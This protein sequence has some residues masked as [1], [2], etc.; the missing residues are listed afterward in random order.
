MIDE[1]YIE[2]MNG[3]IDGMNSPEESRELEEYLKTHPEAQSHFDQLHALGNIFEEAKR[4]TPPREMRENV[5]SL[6]FDEKQRE[7]SKRMASIVR[8]FFIEQPKRRLLYVFGTG[9]VVGLLLFSLIVL[10]VP[11]GDE[12]DFRKLYGTL[13]LIKDEKMLFISEPISFNVSGVSG[14]V[15]AR[16]TEEKIFVEL[17]LVSKSQARV[18]IQ[19]D[20]AVR[21]EG[22]SVAGDAEHRTE[23]TKEKTML[24]HRGEREYLFL[25]SDDDQTRSSITI[26]VLGEDGQF[27]EKR[28][29]P[30]QE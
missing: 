13:T 28:I 11:P 8:S 2:L 26:K 9:L 7:E 22:L 19:H 6:L 1:R 5:L 12:S 20:P 10:F 23:I 3:E 30:G 25:F 4:I 27:F 21:F 29:Q 14:F 18:V 16:Y 24:I 17:K 15:R